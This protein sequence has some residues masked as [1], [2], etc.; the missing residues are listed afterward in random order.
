[1]DEPPDRATQQVSQDSTFAPV[2]EWPSFKEQLAELDRTLDIGDLPGQLARIPLDVWGAILLDPARYLPRNGHLLPRMPSA[3]VQ[4]MWTGDHGPAMLRQSLVFA[5]SL[6]ALTDDA[7]RLGPVLDYGVGWGRLSRLLLK[8]VPVNHLHGVD[9]SEHSLEHARECRLPHPLW[10]VSTRLEKGE[11]S[12][13][14]SVIYAFSVF[15]HLAPE[16]FIHNLGR[17]IEALRPGGRLVITVR[18]PEFW[19]SL[20]LN[21]HREKRPPLQ[22]GIMHVPSE[23]ADYGDTVVTHAW[24]AEQIRSHG[25]VDLQT[26]W[27]HA[28]SF[29]VIWSAQ[30]PD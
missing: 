21:S 22:R 25:L 14:Y 13:L 26:E 17:L 6:S 5:R 20:R 10:L 24:I 29:Q 8:Y 30:R 15:T 3:E 12:E 11:L 9:A 7:L 16:A 18:P 1:M 27:H 4:K 28:D 2:E 23:T 19:N